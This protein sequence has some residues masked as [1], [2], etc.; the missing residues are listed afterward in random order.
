MCSSGN[1]DNL[2]LFAI[3]AAE[4]S[5]SL[6][7]P[8]SL[9][10]LLV[11]STHIHT[12]TY[13]HTQTQSFYLLV[14]MEQCFYADLP[15]KWNTISSKHLKRATYLKLPTLL[16][17]IDK[18]RQSFLFLP[19][20][21]TLCLYLCRLRFK[22]IFLLFDFLIPIYRMSTGNIKVHV[23]RMILFRLMKTFHPL[24]LTHTK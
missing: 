10:P 9:S 13:I 14:F 17:P 20:C 16:Y 15:E 5:Q 24:L 8:P 19:A 22:K 6:T 3:R 12:Q 18:R 2:L 1:A 11:A 21:M 7:L 23:P 4:T